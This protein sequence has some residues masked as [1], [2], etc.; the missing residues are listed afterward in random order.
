MEKNL[1]FKQ[2]KELKKRSHQVV[3]G[4][5]FLLT[6]LIIVMAFFGTEF[7]MAKDG[8]SN[9]SRQ[10]LSHLTD[11]NGSDEAGGEPKMEENPGSILE[12]GDVFDS[13]SILTEIMAGNLQRGNEMADELD[14][15]IA[16]NGDDSR[17]LGRTRGIM[18]GLVNSLASGKLM[19]K[20]AQGIRAITHS[21]AA[22]GV[23]VALVTLLVIVFSYIF[24]KNVYSAAMR[25][26]FLEARIYEKVS[27]LDALHFVAVKR[28][29]RASLTM[30]LQYVFQILW[31]FTI[32]GG[33]IKSFSYFAVPYIVAE[34]PDIR[35]L[36]AITLSRRM[37]DGHKWELLK[38]Y[39]TMLGWILLGYVTLGIADLAYGG[40]YRMACYTEFYA[41]I[42]K[43]AIAKGIEGTERLNDKYLFEK[44]DKITLLETYFDVVDEIT[45]IYEERTVLTG[46]KKFLSDWFSIWIGSIDS[47][48]QYDN[49]EG[50]VLAIEG[51]KLSMD[52]LAYPQR[53]NPMRKTKEIRK[54]GNFSFLR[55]YTV[56]TLF[57]FFII[58][59]VIGWFWEVALHYMSYGV[60]VNRGTLLGP[61][62]PIYGFGGVFV[63]ILCSRFRKNPVAEFFAA[64]IVSGVLEYLGAW[65]LETKFHERW[66]SYDGYFLNIQGRVCAEG[67]LAFGILCT[68]VVYLVAPILDF[69][70]MKIKQRVLIII[71]IVLAVL[72]GIDFGHSMVHPNRAEGAVVNEEA[73]SGN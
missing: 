39:V 23:V 32:I 48:R 24:I 71:C 28:W 9:D 63:L 57:L 69:L 27:F 3:R 42:R 30:F 47:K 19:V 20:I 68:L 18:A 72:F 8:L 65:M 49:Q 59:S 10:F 67:L 4:H 29:I 66:W 12:E 16:E 1:I 25:R 60:F 37:M 58:F 40:A 73:E 55:S 11:E 54:Q 13:D 36:E 31:S 53:L 52:G 15:Q 61:W 17:M 41:E 26:L 6:F 70:I 38:F 22:A 2:R 46:A 50:R 43:L 44:C 64:M 62:I 33:I 45:L 56:W 5:Y 35:P 21:D 51:Y 14:A 7:K 34:N